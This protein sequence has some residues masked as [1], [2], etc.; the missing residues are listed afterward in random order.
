MQTSP[1]ENSLGNRYIDESLFGSAGRRNTQSPFGQSSNQIYSQEVRNLRLKVEKGQPSEAC[2][3]SKN[4]LDRIKSVLFNKKAM[5]G[6]TLKNT[7]ELSK[8]SAKYKVE[9]LKKLD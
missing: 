6:D 8:T 7:I 2:I 5:D 1:R 3:I 9:K 4:E